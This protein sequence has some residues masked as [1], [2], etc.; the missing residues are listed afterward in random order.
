[1]FGSLKTHTTFQVA[2]IHA[3]MIQFH[4]NYFTE[5]ITYDKVNR[6]KIRRNNQR[7]NNINNKE[8]KLTRFQT[9]PE[10]ELA[11]KHNTTF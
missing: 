7:F 11:C 1:M 3:I 10:T 5:S 9:Y 6:E 8:N 4:Q 2:R